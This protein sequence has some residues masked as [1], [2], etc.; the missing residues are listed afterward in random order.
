VLNKTKKFAPR[1][2]VLGDILIKVD[3]N[4]IAVKKTAVQTFRD[5]TVVFKKYGDKYEIQPVTLGGSDGEW[6]EVLEGLKVGEEY[7]SENSFL[8]KADVLKSGASHDH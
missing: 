7:V 2:F 6:F 3:G 5:W 8:V 4:A 1:M